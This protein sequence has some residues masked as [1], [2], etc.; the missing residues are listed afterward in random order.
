MAFEDVS[1][2][3]GVVS[4][5]DPERATQVSPSTLTGSQVEIVP[6]VGVLENISEFSINIEAAWSY[7]QEEGEIMRYYVCGTTIPAYRAVYLHTDGRIYLYDCGNISLK[8]KFLG[9]SLTAGTVGQTITVKHAGI[10]TYAGWSW[11]A[12]SRAIFLSTQGQLVTDVPSTATFEQELAISVGATSIYLQ[13]KDCIVKKYLTAATA[14]GSQRVVIVNNSG[15]AEYANTNQVLHINRVAGI[16]RTAVS[17]GER[18]EILY[19]GEIYEAAWT[20][21]LGVPIFFNSLGV[22]TQTAPT[23]GFRQ[24]VGM[25]VSANR[26]AIA[27]GIPIKLK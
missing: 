22:L 3:T 27:I 21:V 12:G 13:P 9:I 15:Q 19:E 11:G 20:W 25:P 23:T 7:P 1:L 8:D 6:L 10:I 2:L 14:L 26:I 24:T 5:S 17:A 18:V 4:T 16:T